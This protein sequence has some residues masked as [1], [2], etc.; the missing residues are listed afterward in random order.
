MS[1]CKLSDHFLEQQINIIFCVKLGKNANDTCAM[2][3]EAHGKETMEKT[4]VFE[5]HKWSSKISQNYENVE[6]VWNLAHSDRR[7]SIN[8]AYYAEIL[9]QLHEAVH[10]KM[11]EPWPIDCI[12]HHDNAPVHR[13]LSVRQFL[14]KKNRL[15]K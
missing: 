3:F 15:L 9:K 12:L 11:P 4:N 8:R 10:R 1:H 5:R 2:L 6:K 7:S 13:A 14:A